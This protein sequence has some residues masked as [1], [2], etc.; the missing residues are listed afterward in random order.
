M[1]VQCSSINNNSDSFGEL[2]CDSNDTRGDRNS[3]ELKLSPLEEDNPSK[4]AALNSAAN[5]LN[6]VFKEVCT[7]EGCAFSEDFKELPAPGLE[8]NSTFLIPSLA[9]K[10]R[11]S[12]SNKCSP[13]IEGYIMLAICRQKL[14]DVV[15]KEW[16]SSYKDDLLRQ[17][18]T[19]WIASKK[20]CNP[21]GI[22]VWFDLI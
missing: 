1:P 2:H 10:F 13:K 15:L 18:I 3:C 22:V 19:S 21:N 7:N 5:S 12:S 14:H 17:F 9:C 8:E 6:R 11:P 4:D 20:H 16:T